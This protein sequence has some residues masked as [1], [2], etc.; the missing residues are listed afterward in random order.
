MPY[1]PVVV[2]VYDR[3]KHVEEALSAL[4]GNDYAELTELFIFSD[5][6]DENTANRQEVM[7]VRKYIQKF[8]ENCRFINVNIIMA[9]E[10]NGLAKSV[11]SGVTDVINKY[12][13]VIV[14]EDDLV[15]AKSFLRYMNEALDYYKDNKRVW[16]ISGYSLPL[17][18][19]RRCK[20]DVYA[21]YRGSS[22]GWATWK[23]RWDMTDWSVSDYAEFISSEQR[24]KEFNRG[25]EDMSDLLTMQMEGK[26]DSWAIRWNYQQYKQNMVSI[27][28]VRS[29]VKNMGWDGSGRNCGK[30]ILKIYDTKISN[31]GEHIR[32]DD[33]EVD[34]K[35]MKETRRTYSKSLIQRLVV[36]VNKKMSIFILGRK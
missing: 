2:F 18:S 5:L 7:A 24:M 3:L 32:F 12:G 11:I 1:A 22:W 36:F 6:Y 29:Q 31:F 8:S 9:K 16:S 10:H 15:T 20:S 35:I 28:P 14:V 30:S 26:S 21:G 25:G 17:F 27:F 13:K 4:N 33:C 34:E 23:D 19:L